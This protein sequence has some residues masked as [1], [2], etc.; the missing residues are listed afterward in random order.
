MKLGYYI[1]VNN[2]ARWVRVGRPHATKKVARSWVPF[3]APPSPSPSPSP[4]AAKG[5][6]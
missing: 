2:G 3:P 4:A 1:E 5:A 6:S